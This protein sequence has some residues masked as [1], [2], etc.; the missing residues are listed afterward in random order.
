MR[1]LVCAALLIVAAPALFGCAAT[2][3]PMGV[4]EQERQIESLAAKTARTE[5][6]I[7]AAQDE[8]AVVRDAYTPKV[9]AILAAVQQGLIEE[10]DKTELLADI[11]HARDMRIAWRDAVD[12]ID[13]RFYAR[14]FDEAQQ[15]LDFWIIK[16]RLEV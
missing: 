11:E 4:L 12:D 13:R 6:R 1:N 16:Y 15:K 7:T 9:N 8:I 10:A 5:A 3:D 14:R 2:F